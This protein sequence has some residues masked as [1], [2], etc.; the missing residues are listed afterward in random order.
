MKLMSSITAGTRGTVTQILVNNA[1]MVE[2]DQALVVIE[3]R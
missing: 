1:D 3:P 2:Y